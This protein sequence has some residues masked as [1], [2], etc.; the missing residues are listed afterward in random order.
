LLKKQH[1]LALEAI[2]NQSDGQTTVPVDVRKYQLAAAI[3]TIV[4]S[5]NK[6]AAS[7]KQLS[8]KKKPRER[9]D[10]D[11]DDDDEE[12]EED[13]DDEE[14]SYHHHHHHDNFSIKSTPTNTWG[15]EVCWLPKCLCVDWK[16]IIFTCG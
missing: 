6:S 16:Y 13:D 10:D 14:Y 7:S 3:D 9:R 15:C 4:Q 1:Q 12:E 8:K 5:S 2:A 11:D